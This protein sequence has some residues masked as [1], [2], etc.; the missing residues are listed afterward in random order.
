MTEIFTNV[1]AINAPKLIKDVIVTRSVNR[2]I[3]A[4][5]LTKIIFLIGV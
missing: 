5:I 4:K 1:K 3:K 2:A